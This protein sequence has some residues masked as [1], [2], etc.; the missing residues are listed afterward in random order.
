MNSPGKRNGGIS[1]PPPLPDPF[2]RGGSRTVL[3][4]LNLKGLGRKGKKRARMRRRKRN[5]DMERGREREGRREKHRKK[6]K[7]GRGLLCDPDYGLPT[8]QK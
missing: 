3:E 4:H 7:H 2:K 8:D 6:Q 1:V 5:R